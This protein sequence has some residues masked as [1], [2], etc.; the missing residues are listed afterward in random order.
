MFRRFV[1]L[2][3][4]IISIFELKVE[5]VD[6]IVTVY[7]S[8]CNRSAAV[9]REV[10][11]DQHKSQDPRTERWCDP[12]TLGVDVIRRLLTGAVLTTPDFLL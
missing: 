10:G 4:I 1:P 7:F 12:V 5:R 2:R 8:C 6:L 3:S 9:Q 11:C